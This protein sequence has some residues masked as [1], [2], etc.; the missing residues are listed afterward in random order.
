[1]TTGSRSLCPNPGSNIQHPTSALWLTG[2][3][4][5]LWLVLGHA[6]GNLIAQSSAAYGRAAKLADEGKLK[7]A[8]EALTKGL[9]NKRFVDISAT[10]F[11]VSNKL[12]SAL[13]PDVRRYIFPEPDASGAMRIPVKSRDEA[14]PK[15][16]LQ[17]T[18]RS[19]EQI[20]ALNDTIRQDRNGAVA[21]L[22]GMRVSDMQQVYIRLIPDRMFPSIGADGKPEIEM[23]REKG[24]FIKKTKLVSRA[25]SL[26]IRP[27]TSDSGSAIWLRFFD[28]TRV[29]D[30]YPPTSLSQ[31]VSWS[32]PGQ[33]KLV[34]GPPEYEFS[35]FKADTVGY[36]KVPPSQH[37]M[38]S[39]IMAVGGESVREGIPILDMIPVV[40]EG[41]FSSKKTV[42]Y[43]ISV[44]VALDVALGR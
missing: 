26:A 7:K 2:L 22:F 29:F 4:L 28:K 14:P 17:V 36:V 41:V 1:M 25:I 5:A 38:I 19:E 23:V 39:G 31:S 12:V 20:S 32:L 13:A 33:R 21:S 40:G 9:G 16:A 34:L 18:P 24:A 43:K 6:E 3:F 42:H 27:V 8:D 35:A 10:V 37:L 44:Y 11:M 30:P 15:W